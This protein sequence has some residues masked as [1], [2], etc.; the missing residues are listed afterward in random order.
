MRR[1]T[2]WSSPAASVVATC[3]KTPPLFGGAGSSDS[4][5]S[6]PVR[7]RWAACS[8]FPCVR[9]GIRVRSAEHSD[10]WRKGLCSVVRPAGDRL[11]L[12]PARKLEGVRGGLAV[13]RLVKGAAV[14]RDGRGPAREPEDRLASSKRVAQDRHLLRAHARASH[15]ERRRGASVQ[16]QW[17]SRY[18]APASRQHIRLDRSGRRSGCPRAGGWEQCLRFGC[19]RFRCDGRRGPS[20]G[21]DRGSWRES[22]EAVPRSRGPVSGAATAPR[23]RQRAW[24]ATRSPTSPPAATA[25]P[26]ARTVIDRRPET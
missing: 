19:G 8:G 9:V 6:R 22:R 21:R 24:A 5:N 4:L 17:F 2:R 7:Q 3:A 15:V 25:A 16:D 1:R 11:S 10:L 26:P 12:I 20:R 13:S 14:P 18:R 23:P